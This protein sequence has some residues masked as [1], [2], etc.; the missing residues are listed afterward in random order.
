MP[1]KAIEPKMIPKIA[2]LDKAPHFP[3][4]QDALLA[5]WLES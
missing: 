2:P 4:M 1:K 3:L 5:H